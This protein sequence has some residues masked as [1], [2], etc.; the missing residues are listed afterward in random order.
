MLIEYCGTLFSELI[1]KTIT[2]IEGLELHS[3]SVVFYCSDGTWY[4]MWYEPDCC[5]GCDI[6]DICGD[7]D[8]LIGSPIVRA[9][10]PS[11][12]D[13]L[14]EDNLPSHDDSW[15]WTFVILGTAK[16]TVT[17]RWFGSSNGYYSEEPSFIRLS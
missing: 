1:G 8:D 2:K 5:A 11:S 6:E 13:G 3:E 17:L 9:E 10:L 16:G 7:V 12:L 14:N 15:T 4:R